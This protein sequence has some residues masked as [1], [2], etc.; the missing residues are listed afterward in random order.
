VQLDEL[1]AGLNAVKNAT[2]SQAEA[3]ER[4]ERS[5]VVKIFKLV[6]PQVF[7]DHTLLLPIVRKIERFPKPVSRGRWGNTRAGAQTTSSSS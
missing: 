5:R 4:L 3:I 7:P 1:Y 6:L 2:V